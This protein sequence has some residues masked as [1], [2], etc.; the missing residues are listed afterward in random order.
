[1]RKIR[2]SLPVTNTKKKALNNDK[3]WR[4]EIRE[5]PDE[6]YYDTSTKKTTTTECLDDK[7]IWRGCL[8]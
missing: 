8:P 5:E 3:S 1:M 2:H 4:D 6:H 7:L